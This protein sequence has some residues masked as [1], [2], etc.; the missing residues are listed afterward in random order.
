MLIVKKYSSVAALLAL[1]LAS[2]FPQIHAQQPAA[3]I[4]QAPQPALMQAEVF[5]PVQTFNL[6]TDL[7]ARSYFAELRALPNWGPDHPLWARNLPS[8]SSEMRRLLLPQDV[9]LEAHLCAELQ[10]QLT[11]EELL[12]LAAVVSKPELMKSAARLEEI[13]ASWSNLVLVQSVIRAP[14]LY[15]SAEREQAKRVVAALR[16]E[17]ASERT[18]TLA[19][20]LRTLASFLG[21]PHFQKYQTALGSTFMSGA[22]RLGETPEGKRA[23]ES[24]M[25]LWHVRLKNICRDNY[26]D[27]RS[28]SPSSECPSP[29][30]SK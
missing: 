1:A 25:R 4:P 15:S 17:M 21:S 13:G 18:S 8:F 5:S 19:D 9:D 29:P 23:F 26:L 20:D 12:E 2:Q 30:P 6:T 11:P 7:F 27:T 14:K 24:L 3:A 16:G 28:V 22:K 10:R